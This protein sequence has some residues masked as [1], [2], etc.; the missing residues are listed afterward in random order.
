M[1]T[2]L[3][4]KFKK[5]EDYKV[6]LQKAAEERKLNAQKMLMDSSMP[7]AQESSKEHSRRASQGPCHPTIRILGFQV[8]SH[9]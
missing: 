9:T 7:D 5:T 1:E 3:W 2:V 6:M 4:P 8:I